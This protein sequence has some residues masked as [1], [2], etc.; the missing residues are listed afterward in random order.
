L[1][2]LP[3]VPERGCL[4]K[5]TIGIVGLY[6]EAYAHLGCL[7]ALAATNPRKGDVL[8]YNVAAKPGLQSEISLQRIS[9][10]DYVSRTLFPYYHRLL[11][12]QSVCCL[13]HVMHVIIIDGSKV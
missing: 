3:E 6:T 5:K 9:T 10:T 4:K 11:L 13:S 12:Y 1:Y 2:I 8:S 7:A